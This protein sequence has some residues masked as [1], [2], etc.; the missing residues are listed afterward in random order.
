MMSNICI[1][2]LYGLVCLV[3][4]SLAGFNRR[5]FI[6]KVSLINATLQ[7]VAHYLE[8]EAVSFVGR[9]ITTN[10]S[11]RHIKERRC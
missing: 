11:M 3:S 8:T 7:K 1:L 9:A 10:G 6:L 5:R 2:S 4:V